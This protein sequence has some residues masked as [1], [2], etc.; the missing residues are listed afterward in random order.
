MNKRDR[1]KKILYLLQR[2]DK[3]S[4]EQLAQ[5]LDVSQATVRRDF[6]EM[7][8]EHL[9]QRY[10]G[11]VKAVFDVHD[12]D[13]MNLKLYYNSNEKSVIGKYAASLIQDNDIVFLDAGSSTTQVIP[14]ITAK[15]ITV[16][17]NGLPHISELGKKGIKTILLGGTVKSNTEAVTGYLATN[18]LATFNFDIAFMGTN[19]IHKSFGYTTPL[20]DEGEIKS[21]AIAHSDK[22]YVLADSTKMNKH[23]FVSFAGLKDVVLITDKYNEDFDYSLVTV[24]LANDV[25]K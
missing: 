8:D 4:T 25:Q 7:E 23:Y 19:G 6:V 1:W 15:N 21:M 14:Y 9:I 16:V 20:I 24:V 2:N 11:G 22:T 18:A 5:M 10:H 17:T 12:E 3:M 13:P